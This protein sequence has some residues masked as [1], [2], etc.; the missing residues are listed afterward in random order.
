M[1]QDYFGFSARIL[2]IR[3][4]NYYYIFCKVIK[5]ERLNDHTN[6][7]LGQVGLGYIILGKK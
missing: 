4:E 3:T 5:N 2:C 6:V 7:K 1:K